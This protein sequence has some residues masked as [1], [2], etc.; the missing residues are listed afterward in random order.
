VSGARTAGLGAGLFLG[1]LA[2]AGIAATIA[3]LQ[4]NN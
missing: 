2:V 1:V 3:L 4:L